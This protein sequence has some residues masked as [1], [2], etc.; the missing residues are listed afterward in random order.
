M[1]S[2][3]QSIWGIGTC[4]TYEPKTEYSSPSSRS[5]FELLGLQGYF[6]VVNPQ[7][8]ALLALNSGLFQWREMFLPAQFPFPGLLGTFQLQFPSAFNFSSV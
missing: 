8:I 2:L 5:S 3:T 7:C 6:Q 1:P 4:V